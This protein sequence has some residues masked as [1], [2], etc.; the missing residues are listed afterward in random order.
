LHR[1]IEAGQIRPTE[2][3]MAEWHSDKLI[4]E[5]YG[6]D[7]AVRRVDNVGVYASGKMAHWSER[8]GYVFNML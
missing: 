4:I 2:N 7:A 5:F 3:T 6:I 1:R 8:R